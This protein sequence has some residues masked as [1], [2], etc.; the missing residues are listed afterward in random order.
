MPVYAIDAQGAHRIMITG[1]DSKYRQPLKA[2]IILLLLLCGFSSSISSSETK[3]VYRLGIFPH[4][5]VDHIEKVFAPIARELSKKAGVVI[6]FDPIR[7]FEKFREDLANGYY[8]LVFVQPFDYV[9]LVDQHA[10]LP[11]A[12]HFNPLFGVITTRPWADFSTLVDL[13]GGTIA[14]PPSNTAVSQL[15]VHHLYANDFDP[16]KDFKISYTSSHISC[17]QK[18]LLGFADACVTVPEAADFVKRKL[19]FELKTIG[20]TRSIAH[21]LFASHPSVTK[22]HREDL[23]KA[24]AQLVDYPEGKQLLEEGGFTRFK[25]V[26]DKSYDDVRK[27]RKELKQFKSQ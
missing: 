3:T 4:F 27:I 24:I 13:R 19:F 6:Q 17:L 15:F 22:Q 10:Y 23:A 26:D 8:H 9:D 5:S 25:L 14:L 11:L 2:A 16:N 20:K 18:T 7:S 21:T 12:S 1:S